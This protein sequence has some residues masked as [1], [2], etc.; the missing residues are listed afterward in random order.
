MLYSLGT[1]EL[2]FESR[3]D[4][5]HWKFNAKSTKSGGISI[6]KKFMGCSVFVTK[7][8]W[9]VNP[10]SKLLDTRAHQ[11]KRLPDRISGQNQSCRF[12]CGTFVH[13]RPKDV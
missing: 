6:E 5:D 1:R 13:C 2:C 7:S 8:K 12:V 10:E 9:W 3:V 11:A 4:R